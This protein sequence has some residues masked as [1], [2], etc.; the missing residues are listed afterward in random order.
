MTLLPVPPSD[1]PPTLWDRLP[2]EGPQA[3][4]AFVRYRD[5]DPQVR[6]LQVAAGRPTVPGRWRHWCLHHHWVQR[7]SAWDAAQVHVRDSAHF[8][9]LV[10][11]SRRQAQEA[12]RAQRALSLPTEAV[13]RKFTTRDPE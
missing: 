6:S 9:T 10:A 12:E 2:Q 11:M 13:A 3:Y 8:A 1:A 7:V 4:A 5:L